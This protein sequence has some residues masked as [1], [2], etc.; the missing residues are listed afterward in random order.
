MPKT[1]IRLFWAILGYFCLSGRRPKI[2]FFTKKKFVSKITC[3]FIHILKIWAKTDKNWG[4]FAKITLVVNFNMAPFNYIFKHFVKKQNHD[5]KFFFKIYI[6]F[7]L[8][9]SL[10]CYCFQLSLFR[11]LKMVK[12]YWPVYFSLVFLTI[13]LL[14][15]VQKQR[16]NFWRF[17]QK[18]RKNSLVK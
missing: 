13:T 14:Y 6:D 8:L 7:F 5:H 15:I 10:D 9:H 16:H 4:I 17:D 11:S 2:N 18:T 3:N 12:K 1:K